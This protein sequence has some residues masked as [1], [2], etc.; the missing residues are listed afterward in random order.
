MF[1][2]NAWEF[3]VLVL[4]ALFVLGPERL[5]GY[6]A[7]FARFIR[8]MREMASGA[9]EQMRKELGPEFDDIDWRK[10]DPR[11]YDPRRI[12]REALSD[13]FDPDD[14]LGFKAAMDD[15]MK[16]RSSG[17]PGAASAGA[18]V[19]A[20]GASPGA[21]AARSQEF[22]DDL[23]WPK[24]PETEESVVDFGATRPASPPAVTGDVTLDPDAT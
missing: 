19:G 5:P 24:E 15:G 10:L 12:V 2:I 20:N 23:G 21:P 9:S 1:G 3:F 4:V 7:Q 11:Q 13:T 16:P 17:G 6:A 14:P 8:Q 18:P 22:D